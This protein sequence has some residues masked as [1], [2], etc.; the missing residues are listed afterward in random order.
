MTEGQFGIW[1]KPLADGSSH[2]D[3]QSLDHAL[4]LDFLLQSL[5]SAT[6]PSAFA[7]CGNIR[8]FPRS[9]KHIMLKF[10]RTAL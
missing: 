4:T 1:E 8:T 5:V 10:L 9:A 3:L 7:T 2:R 6:L